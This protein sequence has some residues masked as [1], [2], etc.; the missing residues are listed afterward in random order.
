MSLRGFRWRFSPRCRQVLL[1]PGRKGC[2]IDLFGRG[3]PLGG[4]ILPFCRLL[5]PGTILA[6]QSAMNFTEH[7]NAPAA[8]GPGG[9]TLG[10]LRSGLGFLDVAEI[11]NL[12][13]R[14]V[15][16]EANRIVGLESHIVIV[17]VE[18]R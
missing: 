5:P 1:P 13:K 14:D 10:D 15:K 17:A 8:A 7:R 9:K 12:P 3:I 4:S 16:A 6:A 2:F 11:L 18:Y